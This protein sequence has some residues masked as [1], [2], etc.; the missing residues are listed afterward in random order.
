MAAACHIILLLILPSV[1][2]L[3]NL[4]SYRIYV[5]MAYKELPGVLASI[6]YF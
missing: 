1:L 3:P 4:S 2:F 6:V 5:P